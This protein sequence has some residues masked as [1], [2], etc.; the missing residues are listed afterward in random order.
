M[1]VRLDGVQHSLN[2][3]GQNTLVSGFGLIDDNSFLMYYGRWL[4]LQPLTADGFWAI[5]LSSPKALLTPV[6]L[7]RLGTQSEGES[8]PA[9]SGPGCELA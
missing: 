2:D 8:R 5:A 3:L 1:W 9:R 6:N 4:F 7:V